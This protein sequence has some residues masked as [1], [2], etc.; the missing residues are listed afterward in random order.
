MTTG[1]ARLE[2]LRSSHLSEKR[3]RLTSQVWPM[4]A[5]REDGDRQRLLLSQR[6]ASLARDERLQLRDGKL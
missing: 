2:I 5:Q 3:R 4:L 1:D 6:H